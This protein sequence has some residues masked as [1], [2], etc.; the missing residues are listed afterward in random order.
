MTDNVVRK[1]NGPF[2]NIEDTKILAFT[3]DRDFHMSQIHIKFPMNQTDS[4]GKI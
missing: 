1:K 3:Y 2:L 4:S